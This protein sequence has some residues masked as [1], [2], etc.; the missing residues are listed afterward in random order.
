MKRSIVIL[1][2]IILIGAFFLSQKKS[3]ENPQT[4]EETT[5]STEGEAT[6]SPPLALDG[7]KNS[8]PISQEQKP[9]EFPSEKSFKRLSD[10]ERFQMQALKDILQSMDDQDPRL[11]RDL[12][13]LSPQVKNEIKNIYRNLPDPQI[14]RKGLLVFLIGRNIQSEEDVSFLEGVLNEPPCHNLTDCKANGGSLGSEAEKHDNT[15]PVTLAYPQLLALHYLKEL[16]MDGAMLPPGL[17]QQ[18]VQQAIES[19]KKSKVDVV[20]KAALESHP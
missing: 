10:E 16:Q 15:L 7:F 11:D 5:S 19:A 3:P 9:L 8:A 12:K 17:S 20:R 13:F 1:I 18:K 4:V 6:E 14:N 2:A